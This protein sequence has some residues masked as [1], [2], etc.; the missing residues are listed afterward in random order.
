MKI[1]ALFAITALVLFLLFRAKGSENS[2][3]QDQ[4]MKKNDVVDE[5]VELNEVDLKSSFKKLVD[6]LLHNGEPEVLKSKIDQLQLDDISKDYYVDHFHNLGSVL[7]EYNYKPN[8]HI[9]GVIYV[10]AIDWKEAIEDLNWKINSALGGREIPNLP[11]QSNY[12]DNASVSFDG[13]FKDFTM[14]LQNQGI[15]M[16]F[17]DNQSDTYLVIFHNEDKAQQVLE[18]LKQMS[19]KSYVY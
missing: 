1:I 8:H 18:V 10:A 4:I 17:L 14:A 6:L 11:S 3:K 13:V 5:I 12:P 15:V 16:R 2:I 7:N 9:P 19:I